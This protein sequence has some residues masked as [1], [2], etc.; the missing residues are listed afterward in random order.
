MFG[1]E[2]SE[3]LL[4]S[5]FLDQVAPQSRA[6]VIELTKRYEQ[7]MPANAD[8]DFQGLRK[9]G[10]EFPFQASLASVELE[11]GSAL[12]G[13]FIDVSKRKQ[14]E[15]ENQNL[16]DQAEISTRLAAM[17]EMAAGIAHEI[18][19][20]LTGVIG[21]S[22][23]LLE[24]NDISKDVREELRIINE[25]STRVKEIIGRMLTFARQTEPYKSCVSITDILDN[26]LELRSY[27]LKTSNILV[28]R[29][30]EPQLPWV[31]VDAGQ[32][33][34]VFLN[35]IINAEYAMKKA[36]DKGTLTIKTESLDGYIRISISDNGPGMSS[37]IKAKLFQPFFT[38]KDPGE[39][40]GL[41]LSLS[42]GIIQEHGGTIK[43]KSVEGQGT[44]FIIKLPVTLVE[45]PH[46]KEVV[47]PDVIEPVKGKKV[48]VVDDEPT[49][50]SLARAI[51]SQNGHVV[52]ECDNAMQVLE[53]L[54]VETFD[55]LLMDLRMPGMNGMEL[56]GEISTRWPIMAHRVLFITGDT[57]DLNTQQFLASH[58]LPFISKPFDRKTL[59]ST[60]NR[61]LLKK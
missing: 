10:S 50:R 38:T 33:Q 15:A 53:K 42:Y 5:S 39:G 26:T 52:E 36:N 13:F 2:K 48:L 8:Y 17:G 21:F 14:A 51:L 29:D 49:V 28:I 20:P 27:V 22:E 34:Q 19:N 37:E 54:K 43:V 25:G 41:G 9:D 45:L 11:N 56:Y 59:E 3:E 60:V 55:I 6:E 30:Y 35:I 23:L 4:G 46:P 24:R 18:N 44:H 1:F 16:R 31:T 12:I 32:L 40:T 57:S 61:L 47:V 58:S 7:D